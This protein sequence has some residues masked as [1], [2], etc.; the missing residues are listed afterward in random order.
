MNCLVDCLTGKAV[1][2]T[3]FL[4][5]RIAPQ[6]GLRGSANLG[7]LFGFNI[8]ACAAPLILALLGA[9]AASGAGG[10]TL[11]AGFVSLALFG[12]A[13]SLPIVLAVMS[14]SARRALDQLAGLSRR[15]PVWTG[16]LL[17]VLGLWSI[18]SGLEPSQGP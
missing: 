16:L 11:A 8:P 14:A 12:F 4:V 1:A 13:L 10:A 2:L 9:A 15:L 7:I 6:S 5:P 18:G 3:G 17:I